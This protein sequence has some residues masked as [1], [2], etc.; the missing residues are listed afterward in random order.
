MRASPLNYLL[1]IGLAGGFWLLTSFGVGNWV[2]D[3]ANLMQMT[4]EE[5]VGTYRMLLTAAAVIGLVITFVW[6]RYGSNPK[7]EG[8]LPAA[9][10]FWDMLLLSALGVGV[11]LVVA[12][13]VMFGN[14][15]FSIVQYIAFVLA[16]SLVTWLLFWISSLLWSPSG[17]KYVPR[18]L[19]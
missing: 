3:N 4:I 15:Q 16:L 19:R 12:M 1:T 14:E 13:I 7:T 8:K 17:V 6:Y 10:R 9:R 18:G 2:A 11:V 5:F